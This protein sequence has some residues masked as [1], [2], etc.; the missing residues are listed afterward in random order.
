LND[1]DIVDEFSLGF[2]VD[3]AI[4]DSRFHPPPGCIYSSWID[5]VEYDGIAVVSF[6]GNGIR[7]KLHL[8]QSLLI[9]DV[10]YICE[11]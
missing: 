5:N 3:A 9:Y 8:I 10:V 6:N 1:Q 4:F 11:T 7:N 2:N